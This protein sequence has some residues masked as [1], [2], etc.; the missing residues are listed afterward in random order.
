MTRA[1]WYRDY[2]TRLA[3]RRSQRTAITKLIRKRLSG[4]GDRYNILDYVRADTA[5]LYSDEFSVKDVSFVFMF[6]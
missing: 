6:D 5:V 4:L 1:S 2:K 3:Y